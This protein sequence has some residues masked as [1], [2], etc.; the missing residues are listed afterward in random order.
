MSDDKTTYCC[1]ECG[2][3]D[4]K[5]WR[6]ASTF[7]EVVLT[8]RRCL[9]AKGYDMGP[10]GSDQVYDESISHKCYVPA[11][12]D[13]DGSYWGYTSVPVWWVAWWKALP[14]CRE[15]CTLCCGTGQLGE[16]ICC[17]CGGT[18]NRGKDR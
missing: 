11:V 4:C 10:K 14:S 16:L 13:L 18:G 3:Q 5:M 7:S 1:S 9:E 12:P 17:G 2:A 15:D 8:C 6:P